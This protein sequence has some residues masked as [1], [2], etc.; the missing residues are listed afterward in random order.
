MTLIDSVVDEVLTFMDILAKHA[1]AEEVF[2]LEEA[3]TRVTRSDQ[4]LHLRQS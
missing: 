2:K 3:A 1:T 4:S